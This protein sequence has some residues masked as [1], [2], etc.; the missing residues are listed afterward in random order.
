MSH[1]VARLPGPCAARGHG[2]RPVSVSASSSHGELRAGL[3]GKVT[4]ALKRREEVDRRRAERIDELV[5][6]LDRFARQEIEALKPDGSR[7]DDV[8]VD[9]GDLDVA[10]VSADDD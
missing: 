4:R 9:H 7:D 5:R 10:F 1:A 3:E 2:R 6:A 8:P